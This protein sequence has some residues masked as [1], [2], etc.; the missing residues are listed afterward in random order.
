MF[1]FIGL[2]IIITAHLNNKNTCHTVRRFLG[3][4]KSYNCS[5]RRG[6][7]LKSDSEQV[8]NYSQKAVK[9]LPAS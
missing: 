2:Q 6:T 9:K 3:P 1:K 8:N 7:L 5:I 4:P